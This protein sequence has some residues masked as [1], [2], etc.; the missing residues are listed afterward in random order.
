[1]PMQ[2][3]RRRKHRSWRRRTI[4]AINS[5]PAF[6]PDFTVQRRRELRRGA[7]GIRAVLV[8]ATGALDTE[9][10]QEYDGADERNQAD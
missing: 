7:L 10:N 3:V 8:L 1:M 2:T 6:L 9:E 5:Y 4:L